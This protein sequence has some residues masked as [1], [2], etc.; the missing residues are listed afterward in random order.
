MNDILLKLPRDPI[1]IS[2]VLCI[3]LIQALTLVVIINV[4]KNKKEE[5]TFDNLDLHDN[6]DNVAVKIPESIKSEYQ[7]YGDPDLNSPKIYKM[8]VIPFREFVKSGFYFI[9]KND[10]CQ[11]TLY[12]KKR[13]CIIKA[14]NPNAKSPYQIQLINAETTITMWVDSTTLKLE[15]SLKTVR[16]KNVPTVILEDP[17]IFIRKTEKINLQFKNAMCD[18]N[19]NKQYIQFTIKDINLP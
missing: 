9:Q 11:I 12:N 7:I 16:I 19:K 3:G 2:I 6:N 13:D 4:R 5:K 1:D 15:D 14:V 17:E 18:I 8:K 10:T